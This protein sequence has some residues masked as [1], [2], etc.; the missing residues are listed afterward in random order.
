MQKLVP[1]SN[2]MLG[3]F[4]NLRRRRYLLE[5]IGYSAVENKNYEKVKEWRSRPESKIKRAEQARRWRA[6]H[7][8]IYKAIRERY[9]LKDPEKV[10]A[11][12]TAAAAK[13]RARDPEGQKIRNQRFRERK[14]QKLT[15]IAGRPRPSICDLCQRGDMG[16]IV[17]DHSHAHGHFRGW[18]CDRC[19]KVLG[20][21]KDSPAL[22]SAMCSYLL[23]TEPK[24]D[25]R[26]A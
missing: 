1:P 20:L 16:P 14:E 2:T 9:R 6:K 22:L 3:T 21:V 18:L 19:N 25:E 23:R 5:Q 8:N 17:F 7:P 13:R 24:V 15:L 26:S 12:D 4:L 10:T 11:M